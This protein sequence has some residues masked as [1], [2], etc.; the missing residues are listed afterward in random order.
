MYVK[1]KKM[2]LSKIEKLFFCNYLEKKASLWWW[3]DQN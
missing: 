3:K 2:R 1:K